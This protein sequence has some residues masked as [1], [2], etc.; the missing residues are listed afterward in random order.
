[1]VTAGTYGFSSL[2]VT[3]IVDNKGWIN[4][5]DIYV[6]ICGETLWLAFATGSVLGLVPFNQTAQLLDHVQLDEIV[7]LCWIDS[8]HLAVSYT[9]GF[10]RIWNRQ[11]ELVLAQVSINL[12]IQKGRPSIILI[13]I[14]YMRYPALGNRF[15]IYRTTNNQAG[16]DPGHRKNSRIM[17]HL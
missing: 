2:N 16:C 13:E 7:H 6:D 15:R 5:D 9:S 10:V 1:M 12:T 14:S 3:S 4:Q 11:K 8:D 17:G